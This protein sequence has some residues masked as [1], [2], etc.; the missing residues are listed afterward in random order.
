MLKGEIGVDLSQ[1]NG[2]VDFTK[3]KNDG[4]RYA[5]LRIGWCG[6]KNN[7]TIDTYFESYYARAKQ[8]KLPVG[9]YIYSYCKSV[10]AIESACKW[11]ETKMIGKTIELPIFLDL[12]DSS[13]ISCGKENLT[14]Q[15]IYFCNYFKS[16]GYK[17][18]VYANLNWF[19]NYLD[20][21]KLS[22]NC[23]WLAQYNKEMT[24]KNRV[25]IWQYTSKGQMD[26]ITGKVDMNKVLNTFDGSSSNN[27]QPVD[28]YVEKEMYVNMRKYQNGSSK[29]PVYSDTAL[30]H[31][32]GNLNPYEQCDCL[33]IV[34][35]RP[36]VQYEVDNTF[37][38]KIRKIGFVNWKGGV[39]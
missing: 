33:G 28:N 36:I 9:V 26:G 14:K 5:I 29:E 1:H 22:N 3:L 11:I 27:P 38:P 4:C 24:Y 30:T 6:N 23:I 18:G 19:Q 17:T 35:N 39:V 32:I 34:D 7:H 16:R 20:Y 31:M 15:A 13:T 10:E 21:S 37:N 2:Y 25:D 12:E 8:V